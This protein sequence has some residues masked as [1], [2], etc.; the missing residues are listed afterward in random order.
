[1]RWRAA[2]AVALLLSAA[3]GVERGAA[4]PLPATRFRGLPPLA[5]AVGQAAGRQALLVADLDA[6]GLADLAAI[7]PNGNAGEVRLYINEGDGG[8]G[9]RSAVSI[10][11][12][13]P[14]AIALA[15][16]S[17]P[18][19]PELGRSPDGIPDLLIGDGS[20]ALTVQ[21]GRG[22]G[23]FALTAQV[24]DVSA[25]V[26]GIATGAFDRTPGLDVAIIDQSHVWIL[27][28]TAGRLAPC[29]EA[30]APGIGDLIEIASGDFDG[31][32]RVDVAVLSGI[33]KRVVP[34][35]G[36]GD[37]TFAVGEPVSAALDYSEGAVDL[38]VARVDADGRDDLLV[39]N[40]DE[41]GFLLGT[42]LYGSADRHLRAHGFPLEY[43][44]TAMAVGDFDAPRGFVDV[45]GGSTDGA[46]S[47]NLNGGAGP[48]EVLLRIVLGAQLGS[49]GLLAAGELDGDT[50]PDLVALDASGQQLT[51]LLNRNSCAG[52]CNGD[53][54]VTIDELT[55][56]IN[57]VLGVGAVRDCR[58]LD[59]DE[60]AGVTIDELIVAVRAAL[61]GC[62]APRV[63]AADMAL[64]PAR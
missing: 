35:F 16:V 29:G 46:L 48:G 56:G 5:V 42:A 62:R 10:A 38:A 30:I 58:A 11:F 25:A 54:A 49:V 59:R 41:F 64:R 21:P 15:D 17:A 55:R 50:W 28:N 26:R 24:L 20:G 1:M 40:R 51:V 3:V 63:A 2:S 61:E 57:L 37:G 14:T 23:D 9:Y 6:D 18:V 31:D 47:I 22:G 45:I 43:D 27:C 60:R 33:E 8:L 53:D 7:A 52:D 4:A 32:G 19:R 12:G 13:A 39:A 44:T 36:N 34:L